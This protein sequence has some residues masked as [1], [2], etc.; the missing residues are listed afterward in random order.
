MSKSKHSPK[1]SKAA[2]TLASP[3]STSTQ[4]SRAAKTLKGHQDKQH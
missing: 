3:K 4:K 2:R 1:V